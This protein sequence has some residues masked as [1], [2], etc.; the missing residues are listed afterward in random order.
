MKTTFKRKKQVVLAPYYGGNSFSLDDITFEALEEIC[1]FKPSSILNN[2][3]DF[4]HTAVLENLSACIHKEFAS[5]FHP[6]EKQQLLLL[7]NRKIYSTEKQKIERFEQSK[8]KDEA[9]KKGRK[10]ELLTSNLY[11]T[12]CEK[13]SISC[14]I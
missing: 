12:S 4:I 13:F 9:M 14:Q 8:K 10:L 2:L 6:V 11:E 3:R 7:G 5:Y 1:I